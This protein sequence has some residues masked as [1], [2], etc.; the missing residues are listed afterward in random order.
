MA[1]DLIGV[2]EVLEENGI[3]DCEGVAII[4]GNELVVSIESGLQPIASRVGL[5]NSALEQVKELFENLDDVYSK[6]GVTFAPLDGNAAHILFYIV[7]SL[8]D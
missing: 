7:S 6:H 1:F 3:Y 8:Q 2:Y 5:E 4:D